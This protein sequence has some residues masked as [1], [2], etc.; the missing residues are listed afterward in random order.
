MKIGLIGAGTMGTLH[1][2]AALGSPLAEFVAVCDSV[3]ESAERVAA[4]CGAGV[5]TDVDKMLKEADIDA[6]L[7]ATPDHLHAEPVIKAADAKKA[8]L[9]EKPFASNRD[10]AGRML[11]AI[12]RNG[13]F[14]QMAHLFR[15]IPFYIHMK[16]AAQAG[17]LG[18]IV[19]TSATTLNKIFVPT[20]MLKWAASSS[21]SWFLL[22]HNIDAIMWICDSRVKK[23]SAVGIKRKLVSMGIDTYDIIKVIAEME[24]GAISNFEA[25]W[26]LPN[27]TPIAANVQM[28]ICGTEGTM[29][30]GSGDPIITKSTQTEYSIPG[31]LDFDLYGYFSGLHRNIIETFARSVETKTPPVTNEID[32]YNTLCVLE[33][34]D[35][36]MQNGSAEITIEY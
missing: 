15:F 18:E 29:K 9:L 24:S 5:Y 34:I 7:I 26:I 19:S 4:L 23:L 8:I 12:R 28:L 13:T 36:S 16:A 21:P 10:D 25:N 31:I 27:T 6:V 20:V 17:E 11:E 33:A 30:L 2:R 32:G 22:S 1:T 3:P 35:R 14:V